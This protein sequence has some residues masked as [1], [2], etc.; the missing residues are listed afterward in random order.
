MKKRKYTLIAFL[1]LACI[2]PTLAQDQFES[3]K[4]WA[5]KYPI[6]IDTKPR[7][8]I[9]TSRKLRPML[10]KLLG[11]KDYKR[12]AHGYYVMSNIELIDDYLIVKMCEQHNCPS[13]NSFMA[14]NV[15]E[16]DIHVAF[17]EY[18][19]VEWYHTRGKAK[20]LPHSVLYNVWW[21][22]SPGATDKVKE[23]TKAA[24]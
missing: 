24:T 15:K 22:Q 2:T 21:M 16:D 6:N 11:A 13:R 5:G 14:V 20:D 17:Y 8:S 10:L 3:L 19:S 7:R 18:G 12:L 9:Y 1:L 4:G 23:S